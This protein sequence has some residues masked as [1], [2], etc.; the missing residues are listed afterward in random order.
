MRPF[1]FIV[2]LS[3]ATGLALSPVAPAWA[4]TNASESAQ[5]R[6]I[7]FVDNFTAHFA[8]PADFL[9]DELKKMYV[10]GQKYR[11]L[12]FTVTQ[13]PPDAS[14]WLGGTVA[15]MTVNGVV[16]RRVAHFTAIDN[17][18]QFLALRVVYS[19]GISAF[20][21]YDVRPTRD[22]SLMQLIVHARQ[23]VAVGEPAD[24]AAIRAAAT[25]LSEYHYK[26]LTEMWAK[27]IARIEALYR[28]AR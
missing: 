2:C 1:S 20:V 4:Q 10:G 8:V 11:D 24:A 17:K 16:D 5:E 14:A 9:W 22:G 13:I 6:Q 3:L 28:N 12:G 27:D 19:D 25:E 21:S 7:Q 23:T 18:Q 15:E 26:A